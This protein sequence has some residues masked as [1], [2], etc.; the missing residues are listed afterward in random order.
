[1]T[2]S[3]SAWRSARVV[4]VHAN[5]FVEHTQSFRVTVRPGAT[6]IQFRFVANAWYDPGQGCQLSNPIVKSP[7]AV[8]A[9]TEAAVHLGRGRP[10]HGRSAR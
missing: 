4:G 8:S 3:T 2:R 10:G 6:S 1:M 9:V 7:N 5:H